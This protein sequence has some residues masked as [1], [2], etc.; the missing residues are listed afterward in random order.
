[1][2]PGVQDVDIDAWSMDPSS[3]A[4]VRWRPK[5]ELRASLLRW[6]RAVFDAG[7]SAAAH[8]AFSESLALGRLTGTAGT[9]ALSSTADAV[10]N[11]LTRGSAVLWVLTAQHWRLSTEGVLT[12]L[13]RVQLL[14]PYRPELASWGREERGPVRALEVEAEGVWCDRP[15]RLRVDPDL[16][17]D[18]SSPPPAL[19]MLHWYDI[20]LR[21]PVDV[22]EAR[23]GPAKVEGV[24]LRADNLSPR[25]G[26]HVAVG[27][28]GTTLSA[29]TKVGYD[30]H[31]HLSLGPDMAAA[32]CLRVSEIRPNGEVGDIQLLL[33]PATSAPSTVTA[34]A[35]TPAGSAPVKV[36][37]TAATPAGSAPVKVTTT[38][39]P[40]AA[41]A[42]KPAPRA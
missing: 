17:D 38:A 16:A 40:S 1:M 12:S 41:A 14:T 32:E 27:V 9:Q 29:R 18:W 35:A 36:T 2:D 13:R 20:G 23:R 21:R 33:R 25:G 34:T 3:L 37:A 26:W 19:G 4:R 11:G 31:F 6:Q 28:E 30:G 42:P 8:T 39:A 10:L 22:L 15:G 5:Q 24:L 7:D